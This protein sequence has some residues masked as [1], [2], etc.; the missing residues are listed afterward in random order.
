MGSGRSQETLNSVGLQTPSETGTSV[1]EGE[2]VE[3]N[4]FGRETRKKVV[5]GRF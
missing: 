1:H 5:V 3:G 2:T 4:Y